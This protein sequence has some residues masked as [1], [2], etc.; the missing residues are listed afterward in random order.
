MVELQFSNDEKQYIASAIKDKY[1]TIM[2]LTELAMA[3]SILKKLG[4]EPESEFIN[5]Q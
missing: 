3:N 2:D 5:A 1:F 4:I